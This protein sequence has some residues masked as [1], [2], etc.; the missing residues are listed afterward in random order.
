MVAETFFRDHKDALI[1]RMPQDET[2]GSAS[3]MTWVFTAACDAA[4]RDELADYVVKNFAAVPG[5]D[6][7][8]KQAIESMDQCIANRKLLEP[9]IKA[10]LGGYRPPPPPRDKDAKPPAK[11][12]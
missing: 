10:W 5:G 7:V 11:N 8:T 12:K 4:R 9:E 2:A 6:R 1:K 3:S